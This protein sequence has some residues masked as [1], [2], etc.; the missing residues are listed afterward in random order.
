[1]KNNKAFT[2]VELIVCFVIIS[3]LS[4]VVFQTVIS[5][6]NKQLKDITYNNFITF[7]STINMSIQSDLTNKTISA[8]EFCGKNCYRIKFTD[9]TIKILSI[10]DQKQ[11]ITY[12]GLI[13]RLPANFSFYRDIDITQDNLTT[14]TTGQ[15]DALLTIRIPVQSK[16]LP[17]NLDIIYVYQYDDRVNNIVST[18]S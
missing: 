6:Q 5:I 4:L 7:K 13:E 14:I 10:D 17:G 3:I 16:I 15:Y 11:L 1:M 12:G 2:L 9:N 8:L 18:V